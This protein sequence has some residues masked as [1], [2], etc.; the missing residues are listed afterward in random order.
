MHNYVYQQALRH[1]PQMLTGQ[2]W[3]LLPAGIGTGFYL[4]YSWLPSFFRDT[5]FISTCY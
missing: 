3:L 2:L 1:T 5:L 4:G